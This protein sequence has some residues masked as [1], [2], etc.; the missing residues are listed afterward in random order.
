MLRI[1]P[2][3]KKNVL[4]LILLN[5][6]MAVV[7]LP[8]SIILISYR[9]DNYIVLISGVCLLFFGILLAVFISWWSIFM[10]RLEIGETS[11]IF[12]Y[13][14]ASLLKHTKTEVDYRELLKLEIINETVFKFYYKQGTNK[15]IDLGNF[16]INQRKK[17]E[18]EIL[19]RACHLNGYAVCKMNSS[20]N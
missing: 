14:Y 8:A 15:S 4:C 11:F 12:H 10:M 3:G 19:K 2:I 16:S 7:F 13:Y 9:I 1:L 17:I 20:T 18:L 6:L 5:I